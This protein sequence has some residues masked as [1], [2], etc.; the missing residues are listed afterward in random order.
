MSEERGGGGEGGREG[1]AEARRERRREGGKEIERRV[2]LAAAV[3]ASE[4]GDVADQAGLQ[5]RPSPC[6]SEPP[7]PVG[8]WTSLGCGPS[9]SDPSIGPVPSPL[10]A[11]NDPTNANPEQSAARHGAARQA[12]LHY[13]RLLFLAPWEALALSFLTSSAGYSS[14]HTRKDLTLIRHLGS[15]PYVQHLK[16]SCAKRNL[17]ASRPTVIDISQMSTPT[18][19]RLPRVQIPRLPIILSHSC[20]FGPEAHPLLR[21][22]VL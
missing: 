17:R 1:E 19:K 16:V 4:T 9:P 10:S 11:R 15:C 7:P 2:P 14:P 8:P 20:S 22:N 18:P 3:E 6:P 13:K 21:Y 12:T 5:C